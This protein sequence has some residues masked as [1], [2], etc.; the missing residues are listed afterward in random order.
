MDVKCHQCG[1]VCNMTTTFDIE[2]LGTCVECGVCHQYTPVVRE[3]VLVTPD[4]P[5]V[6]DVIEEVLPESKPVRK[7]AR[8]IIKGLVNPSGKQK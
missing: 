3:D 4:I 8:S 2:G 5:E 7:R 6:A 1:R